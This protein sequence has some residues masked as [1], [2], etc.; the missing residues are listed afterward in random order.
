MPTCI[1]RCEVNIKPNLV[2]YFSTYRHH[3]ISVNA[4]LLRP[5]GIS[6]RELENRKGKITTEIRNSEIQSENRNSEI[7]LEKMDIQSEI[8]N[9]AIP[10]EIEKSEISLENRFPDS[11]PET[12]NNGISSKT[13]NGGLPSETTNNGLS[14]ETTNSESSSEMINSGLPT[15]TTN[16]GISLEMLNREIPPKAFKSE[17]SESSFKVNNEI[18]PE[19]TISTVQLITSDQLQ[20]TSSES[21]T[22]TPV[23]DTKQLGIMKIVGD[24][25]QGADAD[26]TFGEDEDGNSELHVSSAGGEFHKVKQILQ[27]KGSQQFT[28]HTNLKRQTAFIY[29]AYQSNKLQD[30][31]ILCPIFLH[32]LQAGIDGQQDYL[33]NTALNYTARYGHTTLVRLLLE[34][35][36]KPSS[37]NFSNRTPLLD[38]LD[39]LIS[40]PRKREQLT[41]IIKLLV[42]KMEPNDLDCKDINGIAALHKLVQSD[43][44]NEVKLV[45]ECG[46]DPDI[47]DNNHNTPLLLAIDHGA[48]LCAMYL[49][50]A[51]C[52]INKKG[53]SLCFLR[54]SMT[55]LESAIRVHCFDIAK[56]LILENCDKTFLRQL[57]KARNP[58]GRPCRNPI[59]KEFML[60]VQQHLEQQNIHHAASLQ[61]ICKSKIRGHFR[62]GVYMKT[63]KLPLPRMLQDFILEMDTYDCAT[64]S[65]Q[66]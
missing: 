64:V 60:W 65:S 42:A 10:S 9:S 46:A 31:R 26:V 58:T 44:P 2:T 13:T 37:R 50:H 19:N 43:M 24:K 17:F 55:P 51:N 59:I 28:R 4:I 23:N 29:A 66:I 27:M 11:P 16:I 12:T 49:I 63:R 41:D 53:R 48:T 6:E 56:M 45:L 52:D 35:G 40:Q 18:P 32:L 39:F 61:E 47:P 21:E 20:E 8:T 25:D 3:F 38:V 54:K 62:V 57:L 34:N 7:P 14:S 33:G 22:V 1:S 15:E 5:S 36:G 30:E